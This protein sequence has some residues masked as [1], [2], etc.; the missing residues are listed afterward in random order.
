MAPFVGR[1]A[2]T[3]IFER[4]H[5]TGEVNHTQ[6]RVRLAVFVH[7]L[8]LRNDKCSAFGNHLEL[9]STWRLLGTLHTASSPRKM[10]CVGLKSKWEGNSFDHLV[11]SY[12]HKLPTTGTMQHRL[13]VFAS[14]TFIQT[15]WISLCPV[16]SRGPTRSDIT[17]LFQSLLSMEECSMFQNDLTKREELVNL[18][19]SK[20]GDPLAYARL[21][22]DPPNLLDTPFLWYAEAARS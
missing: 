20:S 10:V 1:L 3:S 21:Q 22:S 6:D 2:L 14:L 16:R 19:L 15:E 13:H 18:R 9:R 17:F 8:A 4:C 5:T 7:R 11:Q 12:L